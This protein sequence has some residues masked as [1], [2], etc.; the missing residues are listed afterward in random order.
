MLD[1]RSRR[2]EL[3]GLEY[4]RG[5]E[6]RPRNR[7]RGVRAALRRAKVARILY[8]GRKEGRGL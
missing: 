3:T 6:R 8:D 4:I 2:V 1:K 7:M 5:T